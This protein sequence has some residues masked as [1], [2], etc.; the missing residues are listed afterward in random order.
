[1]SVLGEGV[2]GGE[3]GT[4]ASASGRP[5]ALALACV[6]ARGGTVTQLPSQPGGH[7]IWPLPTLSHHESPSR[8]QTE[9]MARRLNVPKTK[10]SGLWAWAPWTS[11]AAAAAA[12][13]T[14]PHTAGSPAASPASPGDAG[15]APSQ[16]WGA[17]R[18]DV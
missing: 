16:G 7:A 10:P 9:N 1:M 2:V 11:R 17:G 13:G 14:G 5:L 15:S 8:D 4:R 3:T 6:P 18:R 12:V